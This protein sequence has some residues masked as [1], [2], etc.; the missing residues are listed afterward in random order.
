[1]PCGRAFIYQLEALAFKLGERYESPPVAV[2]DFYVL[3]AELLEPLRPPVE[4][5]PARNP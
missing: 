1:L 4:R 3:Y 5:L 2:L